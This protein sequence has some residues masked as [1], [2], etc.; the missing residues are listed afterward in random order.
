[1]KIQ[2]TAFS[3]VLAILF[4][5]FKK[6]GTRAPLYKPEILL[7]T[8]SPDKVRPVYSCLLKLNYSGD[9]LFHKKFTG[10]FVSNFQRW[11]VNGQLRYTYFMQDTNG[12]RMEG[13]G[14]PGY[15][16]IANEI[17]EEIKR[18]SLLPY[19]DITTNKQYALDEHAFI[20]LD[21][22]HYIALAYYEKS[23][24]NIPHDL[25]PARGIK[26]VACI[27]QEVVDGKVVWQWDATKYPEFYK[28]SVEK[29][30]FSN[31]AKTQDYLHVNSMFI[32][33][34]D[35]NLIVSCRNTNQ[36]IKIN[37]KTGNVIW[38]LGGENSD[39]PLSQQQY[40]LRQHHA[41]LVD[42]G[43]TLLLFDNGELHIRPQARVLEFELDEKNKK[44]KGFKAYNVPAPFAPLR[45]SVQ[46]IATSYFIG[47]GLA[48]Y[49]MEV[50]PK[51][52]NKS[53]FRTFIY[54]PYRALKY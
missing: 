6:Q 2:L 7:T 13:I 17:L 29:N 54:A 25:N 24:T 32:D 43:R 53:F 19:D 1:M 31:T 40:F 41:T 48:S 52:G 50:D 47:G 12:Y 28:S 15:V 45:G 33:R 34:R 27:I 21:D 11:T 10:L 44:V 9:T 8:I 16:V 14:F 36:V 5:A 38:R 4:C 20:L 22:N 37:R 46:K 30:N 23:P 3:L 35:N 18:L 39:F 42:E 49:V 26:V 51:T